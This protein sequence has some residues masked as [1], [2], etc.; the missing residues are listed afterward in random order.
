MKKQPD[1]I[2]IRKPD[3]K[4]VEQLKKDAKKKRRKSIHDM[5]RVVLM[6]HYNVK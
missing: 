3:I 5:S 2:R 1:E 6:E 4:L